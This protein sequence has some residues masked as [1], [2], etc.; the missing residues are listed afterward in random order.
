MSPVAARSRRARRLRCVTVAALGAALA[1]PVSAGAAVDRYLRLSGTDYRGESRAQGFVDAIDVHSASFDI[2]RAQ[3]ASVPTFGHL[4]ITKYVDR[5]SPAL[6]LAAAGGGVIRSALLS[7]R[8]AGPAPTSRPYLEYC[9]EN[10]A[11]TSDQL[12]SASSEHRPVET[13]AFSYERVTQ[14]YA[15]PQS[16][17]TLASPIVA[18]WSLMPSRAVSVFATGC[19]R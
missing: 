10:V 17:G 18:G 8:I 3:D 16:D 15:Q 4:T 6:M 11:V 1:L 9:F 7:V 12:D 5:A 14:S 13:V 19:G 2:E